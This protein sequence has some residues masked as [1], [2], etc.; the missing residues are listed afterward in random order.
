MAVHEVITCDC[1]STRV[2]RPFR[3]RLTFGRETGQK[4]A[5]DLCG[6]CGESLL[7]WFN[8]NSIHPTK[9]A[10]AE[11]PRRATVPLKGA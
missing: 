2:T 11:R 1:C 6:K 8:G 5:L 10:K 9:R 4:T 3:T 7:D